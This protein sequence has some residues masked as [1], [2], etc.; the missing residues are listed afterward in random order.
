M[1]WVFTAVH[2]LS[3][4]VEGRGY[5]LIAACRFLIVAA[6]LIVKAT[7]KLRHGEWEPSRGTLRFSGTPSSEPFLP[8]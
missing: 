8:S 2:R 1:S 6:F 5:S 3:L 4:I 7:P